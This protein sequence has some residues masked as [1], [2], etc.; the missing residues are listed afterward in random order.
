MAELLPLLFKPE[1]LPVRLN[2]A[3]R[4][5]LAKM[6]KFYICFL[7]EMSLYLQEVSNK[8]QTFEELLKG[9]LHV[10][11]I[12]FL[13]TLSSLKDLLESSVSRH[14]TLH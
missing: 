8:Y 2:H 3:F 10:V 13:T 7:D 14:F 6:P 4:F 1:E 11:F 9:N 5:F 12:R